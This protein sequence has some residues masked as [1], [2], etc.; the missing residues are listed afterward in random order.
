[1]DDEW[2]AALPSAVDE[3]TSVKRPVCARCGRPAA[4]DC[5]CDSLPAR[6]LDVH[7]AVVIVQHPHECKRPL[8]TVPLLQRCLARVH[9]LRRRT[10]TPGVGGVPV[11]DAVLH[12]ASHGQPAVPVYVLWPG[13]DAVD[14]RHAAAAAGLGDLSGDTGNDGACN[15]RSAYILVALD[16]TWHQAREMAAACIPALCPPGKCVHLGAHIND[17]DLLLRTEPA[18]GCV[19]T[20]EAVARALGVLEAAATGNEAEGEAVREALLAPVR[21]LVALQRVHDVTGKGVKGGVGTQ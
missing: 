17:A 11:L 13:P 15:T 7:G 3:P 21:R 1:M 18:P 14:V 10:Y 16:G 19:V 6:P 12:A 20:A 5:L 2:H 4:R 9:V 8:A